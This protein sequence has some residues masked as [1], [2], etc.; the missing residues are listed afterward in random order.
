MAGD[1]GRQ[2]GVLADLRHWVYLRAQRAARGDGEKWRL[3]TLNTFGVSARVVWT[4]PDATSR[5]DAF[6]EAVTGMSPHSDWST[7]GKGNARLLSRIQNQRRDCEADV[8]S[9]DRAQLAVWR[10]KRRG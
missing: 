2:R 5:A 10:D 1:E 4:A 3:D 6:D 9:V 7:R 8:R